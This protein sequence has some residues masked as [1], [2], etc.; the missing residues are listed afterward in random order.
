MLALG[1][2]THWSNALYELTKEREV[3]PDAFIEY[4]QPLMEW[5]QKENS[6]YSSNT[7]GST[8]K[9]NISQVTLAMLVYLNLIG[10]LNYVV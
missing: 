1:S 2:S 5:L 4:F 7:S 8:T 3:S 10:L 6:K 9:Y